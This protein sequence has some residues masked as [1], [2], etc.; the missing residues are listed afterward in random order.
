[1]RGGRGGWLGVEEVPTG[2]PLVPPVAGK[3]REVGRANFWQNGVQEQSILSSISNISILS[4]KQELLSATGGLAG[5]WREAAR[6]EKWL[7]LGRVHGFYQD[8]TCVF[9]A[10][11]RQSAAL[12]LWSK[13]NRMKSLIAIAMKD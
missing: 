6:R 9:P 4:T 13:Y 5:G 8:K 10:Q 11:P 1:M 3:K 7:C 12:P 2:R